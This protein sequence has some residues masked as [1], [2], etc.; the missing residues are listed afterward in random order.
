MSTKQARFC[1]AH[2]IT[3]INSFFITTLEANKKKYNKK[4]NNNSAGLVT[5]KP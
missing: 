1:F 5:V 3:A 4:N 2:G